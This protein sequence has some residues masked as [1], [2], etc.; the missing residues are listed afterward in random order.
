[1]RFVFS[2]NGPGH[3][4]GD[5]GEFYP[6]DEVVDVVAFSRINRNAPWYGY[7]DVFG[8]W[9]SQMQRQVSY[10]KPIMS[11]QTAS[12]TETGDRNAWLN[13]MFTNLEAHDQ[14]IGA[15]YFSREKF[16]GGKDNDY[17]IVVDDWVDP[18]VV[19]RYSAE[20]SDPADVAWIF[21][22]RMDEWVADRESSLVFGDAVGTQFYGEILWLASAGVTTGCNAAGTAFCPD[23]PVTR[24]QMA[25]FL[26]RALDDGPSTTN[27]FD[28]D[29]A[30]VHEQNI[31]GLANAEITFGCGDRVFCPDEPVTRAQMASFLV[32]ALDLTQAGGDQFS[33]DDGSVHEA[34][35]DR[36]AHSGITL[37]CGS[38]RFCPDD[39][40]TRGQMAAFL[41]RAIGP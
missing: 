27:F 30:S 25:T 1:M 33:D 5:Y 37:G 11:A 35:I 12:V 40:V 18:V 10:T 36:L 7:D 9:I 22:G 23:D 39:L 16:E 14:V 6:G 21:D 28:D 17:R 19:D 13:D 24:A 38:G 31:N 3:T 41:Y 2:V 32:R 20:W 15:M 4:F 29:D 34:N 26:I 8:D